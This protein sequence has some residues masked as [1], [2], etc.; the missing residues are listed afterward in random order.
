MSEGF[1]SS[2]DKLSFPQAES[3]VLDFLWDMGDQKSHVTSVDVLKHSEYPN[4]AH[5]RRR[6]RKALSDACTPTDDHWSGR[7]V[8]RVPPEVDL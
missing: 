1:Y 4:D 3:L 2:P 7:K 5:N 8:F 6:V